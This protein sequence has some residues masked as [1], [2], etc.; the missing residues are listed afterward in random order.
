MLG[1][2]TQLDPFIIQSPQDLQNMN[3]NLTAYYELGNDI[4]MSTFGNFIPIGKVNPYFTGYFDGKGYTIT[5]LTINDNTNYAGLFALVNNANSYIRN[6]KVE[7]ASVSNTT[8][9]ASILVSYLAIGTV[10]NCTVSGTVTGVDY[11]AGLIGHA[12]TNTLVKNC[13]SFANVVGNK[14]LGGL[15]GMNRGIVENSYSTGTVSSGTYRGGLIGYNIGT[16]TSSYWDTQTSGVTTS[17]GGTGKTTAEMKTQSTYI[18]WDFT[19]TWGINN[20][21]PFLKVFGTP[22]VIKQETRNVLSYLN[23][24]DS[25]LNKAKRKNILT[26]NNINQIYSSVSR[27][28]RSLYNANSFTLP[29][30]TSV[31]KSTRSVKTGNFNIV[32]YISPIIS[33]VERKSKTYKILTGYINNLNSN[34]SVKYP[35]KII[36][37]YSQIIENCS[38]SQIIENK[39]ISNKIENPSM[40]EVV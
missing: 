31:Q 40:L 17:A 2:G 11:V 1:S 13:N 7:N 24:I 28:K 36:N 20:D 14:Y 3:N 21:Y 32:T 8:F 38:Q 9:N 10:E 39:S 33:K 23:P 18:N 26:T 37:A 5:N 4:D 15:I 34:I 27:S 19:N 35:V 25:Q 29:I 6:V 30:N 16:V 12:Y 22:Q